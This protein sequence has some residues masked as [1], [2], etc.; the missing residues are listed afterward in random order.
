MSE[1]NSSSTVLE[2]LAQLAD[3]ICY[4]ELP[5]ELIVRAKDLM[6][7]SVACAYG[8]LTSTAAV[9][10]L[11]MVHS[12]G[13]NPQASLFGF[14]QLTSAPLAVFFNGSLIRY[15]DCNDYYFGRDPGHPSGNFAVGLAVG[16]RE[17]ASGRAL[18]EAMVMAYE[19]Q[20]RFCDFAGQPSLWKRGWHHSSNVA[21]ASAALAAK[22]SNMSV[23]RMAHAMAIAGSHQNTLAQ[24]QNGGV[25][26]MKATAEAWVAKAGV[27]AALLAQAGITG[28]LDLIEGS[29][30][31]SKTVA[32]EMDMMG[33]LAPIDHYRMFESNLKPYPAVATTMAAISCA[34]E[35]HQITAL[36]TQEIEKIIV[37]LPKFV[38]G[39]P[40][41][42]EERRY[43]KSL[44]SAQ[45]SLYYCVAIALID[46]ACG[47]AQFVENKSG[48]P[49]VQRILSRIELLEDP[50]LT[51]SWPAAGGGLTIFMRTGAQFT[52]TLSNPPGHPKNPL[53]EKQIFEKFDVYV[54]PVLGKDGA[55]NLYEQLKAIDSYENINQLSFYMRNI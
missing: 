8:A 11:K 2:K 33:I 44:E 25:A 9:D 27:E 7:D 36:D 24:L 42:G 47:K 37:R 52:K 23:D 54:S 50:D 12:L 28:P 15:L 53:S 10:L 40:A 5:K 17:G 14:R 34:I 45:H 22:L 41:A 46:G 35:L 21:F 51:K 13:G 18:I 16:Q 30:G 32:A 38:L 31:W 3:T 43:P 6:I 55:V 49:A 4:D 48:L 20:S 26:T 39:T 1:Q 19:V 29:S